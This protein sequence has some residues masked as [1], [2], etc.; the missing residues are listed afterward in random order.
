MKLARLGPPGVERPAVVTD[1]ATYDLSGLTPDLDGAFF[2]RGGVAQVGRALAAGDL[3]EL[4]DA[5]SL[6]AGPPLARPGAVVC[7][8]LNYAAHAA[9][10]G[11]E[12][13]PHPVLFLKTPNTVGG[14]ADPVAIPRGS[15]WEV[16]L[17]VVELE[18][19][20]L[21]RQRH[22]MVAG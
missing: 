7:I 6:R 17:G 16:E 4:T 11:A 8:G 12:P 20:G 13:P 9:E 14:P 1:D 5:G 2:A 21:G 3:P 19:D 10:S 18:I 22:E 15:D